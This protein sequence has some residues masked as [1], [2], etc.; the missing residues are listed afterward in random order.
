M[1][2]EDVRKL[3]RKACDEAGSPR[4]WALANSLSPSYV[5]DVLDKSRAPGPSICAALGIEKS[6]VTTYRK[7]RKP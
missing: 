1:N 4:A 7:A 3:L 6:T 2:E 5:G